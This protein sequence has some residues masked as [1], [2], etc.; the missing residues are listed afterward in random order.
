MGGPRTVSCSPYCCEALPWT[1]TTVDKTDHRGLYNGLDKISHV[2]FCRVSQVERDYFSSDT[3]RVL[4]LLL[5]LHY[6]L[7]DCPKRSR[8]ADMWLTEPILIISIEFINLQ[9]CSH[10]CLVRA[11]VCAGAAP[12]PQCSTIPRWACGKLRCGNWHKYDCFPGARTCVNWYWYVV[13]QALKRLIWNFDGAREY[14]PLLICYL[15]WE[16]HQFKYWLLCLY[17]VSAIA[18]DLTMQWW[19]GVSN[20]R[21]ALLFWFS[22]LAVVWSDWFS[23][24]PAHP[25]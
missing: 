6:V 16:P 3:H 1:K 9:W 7:A 12:H 4:D 18:S 17:H 19:H 2:L 24:W 11:H 22:P 13:G 21:G 5:L 14:S 20:S 10:N 8:C 15:I 23:K 25:P